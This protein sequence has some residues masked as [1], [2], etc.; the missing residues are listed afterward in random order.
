MKKLTCIL[1]SVLI[2]AAAFFLIYKYTPFLSSQNNSITVTGEAKSK[3]TTQIA[4]FSAS[5]S[6]FNETKKTAVD[7]VNTKM[8]AIITA[9]KDFGID[10]ADIQTQNVS[11]NEV[12]ENPEMM[13]IYPPTPTKPGWQASNSISIALRSIDQASQ[14]TDLLASLEATDVSGPYFSVDDATQAQADL[15]T[16]A[17]ENAR[18]K[19]DK[20]AKASNRK[21]GKV[22]TVTE[23]YSSNPGP[24][25]RTSGI[26]MMEAG[27]P[28][29]PGSETIAQTVTVTFQLK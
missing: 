26:D 17:I 19:A 11:V 24:L 16:Q 6:I 1:F 20:I 9:L 28:V 2:S 25:Y 7:E 5:V 3:L 12:K 29:Q 15:L 14:L 21:L 10:E 13:L 27:A 8:T 23:G 22:I 18:E 4:N